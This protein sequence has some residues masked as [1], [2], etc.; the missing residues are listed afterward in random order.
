MALFWAGYN[1]KVSVNGVA[2][3][4][5]RVA[6]HGTVVDLD[7]TNTEGAAGNVLIAT[8]SPGFAGRIPGIADLEI[9]LEQPTFD[10]AANPWLAPFSLLLGAYANLRVWK[11]TRAGVSWQDPSALVCDV[12]DDGDVKGL[13]VPSFTVRSDG[14][15]QHPTA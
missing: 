7:V 2:F 3:T 11:N 13:Q 8:L 10:S 12:G 1:T 9:R 4:V 15:F 14:L 6:I 5:K